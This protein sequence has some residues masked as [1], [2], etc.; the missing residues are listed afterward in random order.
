MYAAF[1]AIGQWLTQQPVVVQTT[2]LLVLLLLVGGAVA[3]ALIGVID[4]AVG[5]FIG[6]W[7]RRPVGRRRVII[8]PA[9]P[10]RGE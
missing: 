1:D 4:M 7:A 2:L 9:G 10:A 8:E 6:R 5:R 3:Y